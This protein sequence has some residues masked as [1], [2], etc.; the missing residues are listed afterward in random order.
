MK[1]TPGIVRMRRA[2]GPLAQ[3]AW[4]MLSGVAADIPGWA[5]VGWMRHFGA[6]TRMPVYLP[7]PYTRMRRDPITYTHSILAGTA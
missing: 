1:P 6:G 7:V 2:W 3:V 5:H 4:P